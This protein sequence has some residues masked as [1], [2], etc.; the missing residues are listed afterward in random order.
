MSRCKDCI[1]YEHRNTSK[2]S[3]Y[4]ILWQDYVKEFT[5][6]CEDFEEVEEEEE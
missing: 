2:G 6:I 4:C 5:T 3:G 1:N